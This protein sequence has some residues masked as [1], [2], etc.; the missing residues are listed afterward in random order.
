MALSRRPR[1]SWLVLGLLLLASAL[2]LVQVEVASPSYAQSVTQTTCPPITWTGAWTGAWQTHSGIWTG[3][4][5]GTWQTPTGTWTGTWT[6]TWHTGTWTGTWQTGTWTGTWTRTWQTHSGIW[7][8]TW[9]TP[10]GSWTGTWSNMWN[11]CLPHKRHGHLGLAYGWAH[12]NTTVAARTLTQ[13]ILMNGTEEV[14][15]DFIAINASSNDQIIRNVAFNE[16]VAQIE[17][18]RNGSIQLTVD[19]S[20]KPTEVF[21][22]DNLLSEAQSLNG[23]TPASEAWVYNSNSQA[24]MIFADPSS[25]TLV[26]SVTPSTSTPVPEYPTAVSLL[27]IGCLAISLLIA[28][29]SRKRKNDR[30]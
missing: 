6:R 12:S 20:V 26:Y 27:L 13:P 7:T 9:Q 10:T 1:S 8:V 22:D 25:V 14:R 16:S 2:T 5:S 21:A 18:D 29:R 28:R 3:T 17:F 11:P 4:W 19:S 30:I 23:L 15:L 24:L